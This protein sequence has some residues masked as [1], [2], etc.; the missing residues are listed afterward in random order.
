MLRLL[1]MF[2]KTEVENLAMKALRWTIE[3]DNK[4]AHVAMYNLCFARL[5]PED[6][7][8]AIEKGQGPILPLSPEDVRALM[9]QSAA[10]A[11]AAVKV[12]LPMWQQDI[13][14]YGRPQP[15]RAA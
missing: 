13:E 10:E 6:Q 3:D 9:Q 15:H 8:A 2:V 7:K 11:V 1:K 14:I 12:N 4:A 5:S